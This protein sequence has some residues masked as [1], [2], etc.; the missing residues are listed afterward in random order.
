MKRLLLGPAG[1]G[2][3]H[4]LLDE[5]ENILKTGDPLQADSF[6]VLPSAEHT[7]RITTQLLQRGIKGFFFRRITTLS[8]LISEI[9]ISGTE[10]FTSNATRYLLMREIFE[11]REWD[12]FKAVQQ[13]PGFMNLMLGF[14]AELKDA[15]ISH[16]TF[17][18]S[19]NE[20]KRKE[21]DLSGKYEALAGIYEAYQ[22]ALHERGLMDRQDVLLGARHS[23]ESVP[24]TQKHQFSHLWLDG[25]FDF[26][27]L[28]LEYLKHLSDL[29]ENMTITL[30]CDS[31]KQR[32]A[33]FEPVQG[34]LA[35][36]QKMGFKVE[37]VSG[38]N[39]RSSVKS[40]QHLE[41]HL[42]EEKASLFQEKAEALQV[43][44]AIGIQGEIE[45]IA[46]EILRRSREGDIRFS[47]FAVLLRQIGGYG[48]VLRAV[49]ARFG[50]PV[51]IHERER[52]KLSP[53]VETLRSLLFIFL[54][55]WK[56]EPL[57]N[58]LKSSCVRRF[59]GELFKDY[60]WISELENYACQEGVL[61]GREN[62]LRSWSAQGEIPKDWNE[63]K[64]KKLQPLCDLEDA[65]TKSATSA[66]I[67][68][69]LQKAISETFQIFYPEDIYEEAVRRDAASAARIDALF[70][71]IA[72]QFSA[73]DKSEVT[74]REFAEH[75]L[76]LLEVDLVSLHERNVNR[77]QVYDVSL[78]RQKEY[79]VVFVAGLLEKS[80][81]IHL[82]EDPVLSDWERQLFNHAAEKPLRLYKP[83]QHLERY[84]FYLAVTRASEQL[85]LTYP[86]LDLEGKESLP[87]FY[88]NEVESLFAQPLP[89]KKQDLSHPYPALE[90]VVD[91]RELNLS[92]VGDLWHLH[93]RL[94]KES[95]AYWLSVPG[96]VHVPAIYNH[97][98]N[99]AAIHDPVILEKDY[100]KS[101]RTSPT[102]LED[103]AKC[104]YKYFAR[105]VLKLQDPQEELN[106][107]IKGKIRHKVLENF[108]PLLLKTPGMSS[109]QVRKI[110]NQELE[111]ALQSFPLVIE[112][113]Y[114]RDL[115]VEEIRQMIFN[116]LEQEI[117][118]LKGSTLQPAH[119]ELSFG[120]GPGLPALEF[121]DK[122]RR[123]K[124]VGQIDRVD[125]DAQN[126]TAF[127]IDYKTSDYWE[128]KQL[129]NGTSLQLPIYLMV[130]DKFLKMNLVGAQLRFFN[131]DKPKGFFN[132]KYA[133][134]YP[135]FSKR[136]MLSEE[137]FQ[138]LM[139][140]T[141]SYIKQFTREMSE[142]K[143]DVLP[144]DKKSCDFC[145]YPTVC[146]IK[147][148]QVPK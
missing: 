40:I 26:S 94:Q 117:A 139:A 43:F 88:V 92:I 20:L 52:L 127:V 118:S 108:M 91:A 137:E 134:A 143:I 33:L 140:Q 138:G 14:I 61:A 17:R 30:T 64:I 12:Y 48:R 124:I 1:S 99:P 130:V 141:T 77:V 73:Q 104:P 133:A 29:T 111:K 31:G 50:I 79:R 85:I 16:E 80:F 55:D 59:G 69:H 65:L 116:F 66:Q 53:L 11:K 27:N 125:I 38:S 81:P 8:H 135:A 147:K 7:D 44:E 144:R 54:E 71:E 18:H 70:E 49:F 120:R 72:T 95:L 83:R 115:Y 102:T 68:F 41:R 109:E 57:L 105:R 90:D 10:H 126:K 32:T 34:T 36:L 119:F 86:R 103:Y 98:E 113:K 146:R 15:V 82:K 93:P 22:E 13:T 145:P 56:R 132:E 110:V 19:M 3:T 74:F 114:Q 28:Q 2:K 51:E 5:F 37:S 128:K 84:L 9:F 97:E 76:R 63:I 78:A 148:W 136:S 106:I 107:F 25:F 6:F 42:F 46:R 89:R 131:G 112:K 75:L 21:P 4:K 87:S 39:K 62:W 58:F 121:E 45:M 142:G 100:F 35:Q 96:L 60:D 122:E 23:R 129:Q 47:D 24:G 123:F 67:I 101:L